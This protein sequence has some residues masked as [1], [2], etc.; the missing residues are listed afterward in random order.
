MKDHAPKSYI[1]YKQARELVLMVFYCLKPET[2]NG[3]PLMHGV[4]K[5]QGRAVAVGRA[6]NSNAISQPYSPVSLGARNRHSPA[7]IYE[8]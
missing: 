6:V 8:S 2:E 5:S 7:T 3:G 1:L 4:P